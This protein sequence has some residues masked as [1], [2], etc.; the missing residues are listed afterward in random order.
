MD[1]AL[2]EF[3]AAILTHEHVL[4][5]RKDHPF[6]AIALTR[7]HER[8]LAHRRGAL[9]LDLDALIEE[10]VEVGCAKACSD[11]AR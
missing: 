11:C 2:E 1:D 7:H 9:A 4:V 5:A 10:D 8:R 6:R 3:P